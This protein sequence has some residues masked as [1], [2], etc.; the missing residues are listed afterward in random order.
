D[1]DPYLVNCGHPLSLLMQRI[2]VYRNN[3][4]LDLNDDQRLQ[5]VVYT[6]EYRKLY[7]RTIVPQAGELVKLVDMGSGFALERCAAMVKSY[8]KED[9]VPGGMTD[10]SQHSPDAFYEERQRWF[11]EFM[12]T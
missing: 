4:P 10:E 8:V 1:T 7:P 12:P 9:P 11:D 5:V 6:S 3:R 2:N